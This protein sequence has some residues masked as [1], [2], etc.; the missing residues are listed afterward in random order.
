MDFEGRPPQIV[1][2]CLLPLN[3]GDLRMQATDDFVETLLSAVTYTY[4]QGASIF[5]T[6][7]LWDHTDRNK[8]LALRHHT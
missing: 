3:I 8:H 2:L 1:I 5:A 6:T 4:F 7:T